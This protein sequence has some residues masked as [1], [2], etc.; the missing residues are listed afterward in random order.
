MSSKMRFLPATRYLRMYWDETSQS[1]EFRLSYSI[2]QPGIWTIT[3]TNEDN[4]SGWGPFS[5]Y[6][7]LFPPSS[8]NVH[9]DFGQGTFIEQ[10]HY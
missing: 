2:Y 5:D 7:L 10:T 9:V 6:F 8:G 1:T 3:D 4:E